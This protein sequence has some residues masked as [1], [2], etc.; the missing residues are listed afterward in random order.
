MTGLESKSH[1]LK[2]LDAGCFQ[3]LM[4]PHASLVLQSTTHQQPGEEEEQLQN[5]PD[6]SSHQF[7]KLR[8]KHA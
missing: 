4:I 1:A 3:S 8:L 5:L 2:E 7:T 6:I